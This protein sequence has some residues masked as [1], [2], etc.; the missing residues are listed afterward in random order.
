MEEH[1]HTFGV[2][3]F[4]KECGILKQDY[5][6]KV[7]QEVKV[8]FSIDK[9]E[10]ILNTFTIV[11][12]SNGNVLFKGNCDTVDTLGLIEFYKLYLTAK[13]N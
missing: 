2:Q 6:N 13:K 9:E 12:T 1:K 4:C 3:G 11:K 8:S 5:T 7:V 10:S